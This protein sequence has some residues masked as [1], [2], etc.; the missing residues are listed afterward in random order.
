ML[1]TSNK[2]VKTALTANVLANFLP[3]NYGGG[4]SAIQNLVEQVDA[5]RYGDRSIYQTAI[6][7]VEGGSFLVYYGDCRDYLKALLDETEEE[8]TRFSDD[9]V[10]HLYCHLMARTMAN[11]YE[12]RIQELKT[13]GKA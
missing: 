2:T 4:E 1:R 7:Y 13:L 5:M 10:W 9:K 11:L 8:A 6:D 3:I 12:A